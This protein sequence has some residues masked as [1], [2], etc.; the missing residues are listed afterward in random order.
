MEHEKSCRTGAISICVC[1][2][3]FWYVLVCVF[4]SWRNKNKQ[5]LK[6]RLPTEQLKG[7]NGLGSIPAWPIFHPDN[8]QPRTCGGGHNEAKGAQFATQQGPYCG[9][10]PPSHQPKLEHYTQMN[11]LDLLF[12]RIEFCAFIH[13]SPFKSQ[14][15]T[16]ASIGLNG[17]E[18]GWL[19]VT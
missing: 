16:Y 19:N 10:W 8:E 12:R 17:L 11:D 15:Y 14:P 9:E 2:S 13:F 7:T 1:I 18:W 6:R 5:D 3:W 4:S